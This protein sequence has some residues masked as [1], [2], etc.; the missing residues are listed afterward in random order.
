MSKGKGNRY[1]LH[2]PPANRGKLPS[3]EVELTLYDTTDNTVLVKV[4]GPVPKIGQGV[5]LQT[6]QSGPLDCV[7]ERVTKTAASGR[8]WSVG[9]RLAR[10][11]VFSGSAGYVQEPPPPPVLE[12]PAVLTAPLAPAPPPMDR[13]RLAALKAQL[14]RLTPE[15]LAAIGGG[16]E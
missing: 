10:P 1:G 15:V 16:N 11:V 4:R 3:V 8:H 13:E 12:L 9:V 2:I 14:A 7:V 5:Q 6:A